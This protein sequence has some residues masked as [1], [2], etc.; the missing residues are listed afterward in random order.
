MYIYSIFTLDD[1]HEA[2]FRKL[3]PEKGNGYLEGLH[4]KKEHKKLVHI[5]IRMQYSTIITWIMHHSPVKY[6]RH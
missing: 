5:R 2:E 1:W 3:E 6:H 4:K